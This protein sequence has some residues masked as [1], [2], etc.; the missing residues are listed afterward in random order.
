MA[1]H[2]VIPWLA[3]VWPDHDWAR[4]MLR[5]GC[6]HHVAVTGTAVARV[7]CHGTQPERLA[8]EHAVLSALEG[9]ALPVECPRP[10][11][12]VVDRGGY[13]GMLVSVVP[14]AERSDWGWEALG[15]G[16]GEL[17]RQLH[18][19]EIVVG[20][21]V[22]PAP[23]SWCGGRGWPD[24]VE[25]QVIAGLVPEVARVARVVV[26]DLL[27][28]EADAQ[29]GFV[30]GDFG[31]HNVLWSDEGVSGVIDFD[32][33][34]IGDPAMDL[35]SLISFFRGR[36]CRH[37]HQR[38]LPARPRSPASSELPAAAG[39]RRRACWRQPV[40]AARARKLQVSVWCWNTP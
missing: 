25:D 29:F 13:S 7:S 15:G 16:L 2:G 31:P 35:A 3:D 38:S 14:G 1:E 23:R 19:V 18:E 30:H 11:S 32:H 6:F 40:A 21:G 36:R 39:C 24:I 28:A 5:K 8:R 27:A 26:E 17:M 4:A 33:C 37:P 12:T 34:C 22:L 20:E 9:L 10:L